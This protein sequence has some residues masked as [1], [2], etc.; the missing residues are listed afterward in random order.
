MHLEPS[1]RLSEGAIELTTFLGYVYINVC[2]CVRCF[3]PCV[4][5]NK[6][7]MTPFH[8]EPLNKG[9]KLGLHRS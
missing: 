5:F 3:D 9:P 4:C 1:A 8:M 6:P 2:V 7:K